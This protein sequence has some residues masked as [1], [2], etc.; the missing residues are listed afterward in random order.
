[1]ADWR[2]RLEALKGK[3]VCR[4]TTLGRKTGRPHTVTIWFVCGD[5]GVVYLGTLRMSRDWPKNVLANPQV[6]LEI[7]GLRVQAEARLIA[8]AAQRRRIDSMI[9]EKYWL[10]RIGTWFGF[11]SEGVFEARVT[12]EASSQNPH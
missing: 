1:M 9:A 5:D 2:R 12:G 7:G 8:D 6:E 10:A 4:I 11:K 3:Y